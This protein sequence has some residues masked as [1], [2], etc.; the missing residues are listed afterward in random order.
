MYFNVAAELYGIC[1]VEK[2]AELYKRDTG[3]EKDE[4][5]ALAFLKDIPENK[6]CFVMQGSQ[7]VLSLYKEKN[8]YNRLLQRTAGR[9]IFIFRPRKKLNV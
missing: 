1:P 4:F 8:E 5:S 7:I 3:L 6:K 9:G 2:A